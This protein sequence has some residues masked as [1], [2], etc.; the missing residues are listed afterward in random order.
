MV[1]VKEK[2]REF[3][4]FLGLMAF[5]VFLI[6]FSVVTSVESIQDFIAGYIQFLPSE[7]GMG[8]LLSVLIGTVVML[9]LGVYL[10]WSAI[11]TMREYLKKCESN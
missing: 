4:V 7:F 1:K 9:A 2:I 10:L 3:G 6:V 5:P 8:G 11:P